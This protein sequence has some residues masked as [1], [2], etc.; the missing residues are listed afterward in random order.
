M[1]MD[2]VPKGSGFMDGLRFLL[3][4]D[5]VLDSAARARA[6]VDS[7]LAAVRATPDADPNWTDEE[8]FEKILAGVERASKRK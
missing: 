2:A 8:I 4:K 1:A 3:D 5:R 6:T 7:M